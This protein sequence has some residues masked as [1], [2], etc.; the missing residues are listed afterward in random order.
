MSQDQ[1]INAPTAATI[2]QQLKGFYRD[3]EIISL[4]VFC[5]FSVKVFSLLCGALLLLS[6]QHTLIG[7]YFC[8][9]KLFKIFI[10]VT[11]SFQ[12]TGEYLLTYGY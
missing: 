12:I 1:H 3:N 9:H 2:S 8:S 6:V 5:L 7:I 10:R 4:L 11:V